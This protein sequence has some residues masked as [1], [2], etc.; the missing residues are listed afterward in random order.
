MNAQSKPQK[1][2]RFIESFDSV[3]YSSEVK[4]QDLNL[5]KVQAEVDLMYSLLVRGEPVVLPEAYSFDSAGFIDIATDVLKSRPKKQPV[6]IENHPVWNP[7]ILALRG[8]HPSYKD[9]VADLFGKQ[10]FILSAYPEAQNRPNFRKRFAECIA[11]ENFAGAENLRY[12]Y[13]LPSIEPR[14][15]QLEQLNSYFREGLIIS[16]LNKP[17]LLTQYVGN[18]MYFNQ[19]NTDESEWSAIEKIQQGFKKFRNAGIKFD[20]RSKVHNLN[21]LDYDIEEEVYQGILE[22]VDSQYNRTISEC[23]QASSGTYSLRFDVENR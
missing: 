5:R 2:L 4:D 12:I 3:R 11:G 1:K 13:K 17:N 10:G 18:I 22:Y 7:F 20:S 9:M 16:A 21:P 23:V 14:I 6:N 15:N 8:N 19:L